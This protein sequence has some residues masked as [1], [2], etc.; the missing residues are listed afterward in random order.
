MSVDTIRIGPIDYA[1]EL[2]DDLKTEDDE[3]ADGW[4]CYVDGAIRLDTALNPQL[5][6]VTLWHEVLHGILTQ[7]G[8]QEHDEGLLDALAHGIAQVLRDNGE[9]AI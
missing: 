3:P 6:R 8:R 7:T 1:I 2:V 5:R 9:M 4:I